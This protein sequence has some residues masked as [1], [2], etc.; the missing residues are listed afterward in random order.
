MTANR[1]RTTDRW[2]LNGG[3]QTMIHGIM[4]AAVVAGAAA[5]WTGKADIAALKAVMLDVKASVNR[6]D[7]RV[8]WLERNRA[9]GLKDGGIS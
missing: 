4:T 5:V 8:L 1:R 6:L 9:S 2:Y 7:S 3:L